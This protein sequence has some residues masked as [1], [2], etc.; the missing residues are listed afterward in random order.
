[1]ASGLSALRNRRSQSRKHLRPYQRT[2]I[3]ISL[4][5]LILVTV[6]SMFPIY[7]VLMTSVNYTDGFPAG[8][9][10]VKPT[11]DHF[12]YVLNP[13][14]TDLLLW[15]RNTLIVGAITGSIQVIV[16]TLLAYAF[17]RFRFPGRR[18]GMMA[19]LAFQIFPAVI[20]LSAQYYLVN[21][22]SENWFPIS[23][24]WIGLILIYAGTGIPYLAWLY[25]GYIDTLP[26]DLEE[27]AY[28][29]GASKFSAFRRVI[30]PLCRPMMAVTFIYTFIGVANEY[31][32]I[33]VLVTAP[34]RKTFSYG[35]F[36][37]VTG[38]FETQWSN[39]AAAA[40]IGSIPLV[41]LFLIAQRWLVSG[42][43]SGAVKG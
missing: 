8:L 2:Q 30:L 26:F 18:N 7:Y 40:V 36:T 38:Q 41:V 24:N 19:L 16:V 27:A 35:L 13:G 1:M 10:P 15:M 33:S 6:L 5:A 39:F 21:W 22:I 12:R 3:R 4:G 32:L 20:F 28:I 43:A 25:K 14:N 23:E 42:L 37:F 34:D 29:D 9:T 17:S 11:L 31:L